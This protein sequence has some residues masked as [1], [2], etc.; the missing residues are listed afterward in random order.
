M[1]SNKKEDP[2]TIRSKEMFRNAVLTLLCEDPA[3]SNLNVQK[4]AAKQD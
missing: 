4:V 1:S 3:I 2:R